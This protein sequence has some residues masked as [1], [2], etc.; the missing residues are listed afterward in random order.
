MNELGTLEP[1]S[2]GAQPSVD[3]TLPYNVTFSIE[4]VTP[5]LFHA[6]NVEAIEEKAAA[7]RGSAVK[8]TDNLESYVYRNADGDICLPSEYVR[9]AIIGAAKHVQDPRSSRPKQG[10]DLFKAGIAAMDELVSLGSKDWD[11]IDQ[12]RVQVMRSGITR[13]RP[14]FH[15][16]WSAEFIFSVLL[17]EYI[18]QAMFHNVLTMAGKFIGVADFRPTYGRFMVTNYKIS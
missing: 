6:W 17:P 2:N 15:T 14:A 11:Y 8:K 16:G 5:M 10:S 1:V 18:D 12:R 4:G 13:R 7:S 9:Q 3:I